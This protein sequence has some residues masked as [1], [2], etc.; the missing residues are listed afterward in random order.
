MKHTSYFDKRFQ[1]SRITYLSKRFPVY[2]LQPR[3]SLRSGMGKYNSVLVILYRDRKWGPRG[4]EA[5]SS[6]GTNG[7][8]NLVFSIFL[9]NNVK[10]RGACFF[11]PSRKILRLVPFD[12]LSQVPIQASVSQTLRHA[13]CFLH[14]IPNSILAWTLM[15]APIYRLYIRVS[16]VSSTHSVTQ[17]L[18]K[19]IC[20]LRSQRLLQPL[21][22]QSS[23]CQSCFL[24]W[25]CRR[26]FW[27]W[28][29]HSN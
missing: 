2:L 9:C 1:T 14:A 24:F 12:L 29:S 17:T 26:R 13:L 10:D 16:P 6:K 23:I 22:L 3:H 8:N 27:S 19:E 5:R 18:C 25:R 28:S 21:L 15:C 7:S 4:D 11:S 20:T